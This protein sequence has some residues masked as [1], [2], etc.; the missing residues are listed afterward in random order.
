MYV[1]LKQLTKNS[2]NC[3]LSFKFTNEI[4]EI[5]SV[6]LVIQQLIKTMFSHVQMS[7]MYFLICKSNILILFW[8]FIMLHSG[9]YF[10]AFVF[11]VSHT[12]P[13]PLL[14]KLCKKKENEYSFM[15]YCFGFVIRFQDDP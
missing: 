11:L 7:C 14:N 15:Q 8:L 2:N 4:I 1:K 12:Q 3:I 5:P 9:Y 13:F 6:V 10:W